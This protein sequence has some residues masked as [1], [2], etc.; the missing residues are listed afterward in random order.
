MISTK[1]MIIGALAMLALVAVATRV[2]AVG[3]LVTGANNP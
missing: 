1:H 2:P 3:N